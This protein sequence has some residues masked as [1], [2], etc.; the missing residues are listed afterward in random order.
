MP[1][2]RA[3]QESEF[4]GDPRGDAWGPFL[5]SANKLE[6]KQNTL[7][8]HVFVWLLL[9]ILFHNVRC[10]WVRHSVSRDVPGG[11]EDLE[12]HSEV[13]LIVEFQGLRPHAVTLVG[14]C[15]YRGR[16]NT[17]A[18][19][20]VGTPILVL[21]RLQVQTRTP[22]RMRPRRRARIR[23]RTQ[24]K[25]PLRLRMRSRLRVRLRRVARRL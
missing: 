3:Q 7:V 24:M 21:M 2:V 19:A 12:S 25:T 8:S 14:T 16:L 18:R 22:K 23:I 9:M 20:G 5:A 15:A 4:I 1:G 17:K 13:R 10:I 11:H 6:I